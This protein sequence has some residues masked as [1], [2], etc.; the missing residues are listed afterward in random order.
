MN[1]VFEN[2]LEDIK[3]GKYS[4][5]DIMKKEKDLIALHEYENKEK[6]YDEECHRRGIPDKEHTLS[7][8]EIEYNN[9]SKF[10]F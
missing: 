3:N 8:E 6:E 10:S 2:I 9:S 1:K 5:P 4:N 7:Q